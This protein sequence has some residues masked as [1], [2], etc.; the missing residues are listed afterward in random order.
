MDKELSA[1]FIKE[2]IA[3][4]I[5]FD[6]I[7]EEYYRRIY[8]YVGYRINNYSDIED[9]T[10][11]I[12][13]KIYNKISSYN[14]NSGPLSPW[15]FT[16]AGNTIKDYHRRNILRKF[17]SLDSLERDIKDDFSIEENSERKEEYKILGEFV[18]GLPERERILISLKYG[19]E[20]S[21]NE[22]AKILKITPNNV[23]VLLH[24]SLKGLRK[25]MEGYY[26]K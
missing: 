10:S 25:S 13:L 16:I 21:H 1:K 22:I 24:R 4:N 12:F 26:E 18:K 6:E 9:L 8:R 14:P 20:L 3:E 15:I 19:G 2:K 23:G 11:Q 7:Y 5:N 17:L